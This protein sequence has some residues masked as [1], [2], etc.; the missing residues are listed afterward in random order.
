M[1]VWWSVLG[2]ISRLCPGHSV[3]RFFSPLPWFVT[4]FGLYVLTSFDTKFQDQSLITCTLACLISFGPSG[5]VHSGSTSKYH[6]D[7][8]FSDPLSDRTANGSPFLPHHQ[9]V[10]ALQ[11]LVD[12]HI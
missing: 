3:P 11:D 9:I 12:T 2:D 1:Q 4:F 7:V 6:S 8:H 10:S 5:Q